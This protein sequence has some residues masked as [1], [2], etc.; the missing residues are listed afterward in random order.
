MRKRKFNRIKQIPIIRKIG[1][2]W[3][4]MV[5]K[6]NYCYEWACLKCMTLGDKRYCTKCDSEMT[7]LRPFKICDHCHKSQT[8]YRKH[9]NQCGN[10]LEKAKYRM[11]ECSLLELICKRPIEEI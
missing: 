9:C 6:N 5:S 7:K 11:C 8:T 1:I 2:M 10:E 4:S 3:S